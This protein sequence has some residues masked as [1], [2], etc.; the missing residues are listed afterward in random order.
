VNGVMSRGVFIVRRGLQLRPF[1]LLA[2]IYLNTNIPT[3]IIKQHGISSFRA[4]QFKL[5]S[6][7]GGGT[8]SVTGVVV[9][10]RATARHLVALSSRTP[11]HT[12]VTSLLPE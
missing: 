4:K 5:P 1:H 8:A 12:P 7:M 6:G 10:S 11:E 2:S 3:D 9:K